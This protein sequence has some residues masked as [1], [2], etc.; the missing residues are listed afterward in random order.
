MVW[1]ALQ[2]YANQY[3]SEWYQPFGW[4]L[5]LP[6]PAIFEMIVLHL[7]G[8]K[9]LKTF[10][11]SSNNSAM[12]SCISTMVYLTI[13]LCIAVRHMCVGFTSTLW[14]IAWGLK[15]A[16]VY[17]VFCTIV[18]TAKEYHRTR[19]CF[20]NFDDSLKNSVNLVFSVVRGLLRKIISRVLKRAVILS[21]P[22]VM[23][24]LSTTF[25]EQNAQVVANS[26]S[27]TVGLLNFYEG[28]LNEAE[29]MEDKSFSHCFFATSIMKACFTVVALKNGNWMLLA[30]SNLSLLCSLVV[31]KYCIPAGQLTL[32]SQAFRLMIHSNKLLTYRVA[33]TVLSLHCALSI[34]GFILISFCGVF[35]CVGAVPL[36]WLGKNVRNIISTAG[37]KLRLLRPKSLV[38]WILG[39]SGST[40]STIAE[41][42]V[43]NSPILG[44]IDT[45]EK[46]KQDPTRPKQR[47]GESKVD[48]FKRMK[49]Y[50]ESRPLN[51]PKGLPLTSSMLN[52][53][54][55]EGD[56]VPSLRCSS[57]GSA[58][59]C[60][61]CTVERSGACGGLTCDEGHFTC[62]KC[63]E[64]WAVEQNPSD[65][66]DFDR[67]AHS[68]R[69]DG[70]LYCPGHSRGHCQAKGFTYSEL[71][72]HLSGE[73]LHRC[74][75]IEC[76]TKTK[77]EID[78]VH[79][80][81][82]KLLLE[83]DKQKEDAEHEILIDQL[84]RLHPNARMCGQCSFGPIDHGWC[85][86]LRA[87]H[88]QKIGHAKIN[89]SC[90]KCGWF[91]ENIEQWPK[92]DGR[93]WLN[94]KPTVLKDN[95]YISACTISVARL[96]FD[97]QEMVDNRTLTVEQARE[98]MG[99]V[100]PRAPLTL[101]PGRDLD[102]FHGDCLKL[103]SIPA[104]Y[105]TFLNVQALMAGLLPATVWAFCLCAYPIHGFIAILAP[106]WKHILFVALL[107]GGTCALCE[108][109]RLSFLNR[110]QTPFPSDR[111]SLSVCKYE[112]YDPLKRSLA[113]LANYLFPERDHKD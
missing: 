2:G 1:G 51:G 13:Y 19:L 30:M 95:E 88:G 71:A 69:M 40:A 113:R 5:A 73:S 12:V 18:A 34:F 28:L 62:N 98:M 85:T 68:N 80:L 97:L 70:K 14:V 11:G 17:P 86:N 103:M 112:S 105:Y 44:E 21:H 77:R 49:L 102:E 35:L 42:N 27:F 110:S 58:E 60:I 32:P 56:M 96:T 72:S 54:I 31:G 108:L 9:S 7:A 90:P 78:K 50:N 107:A 46:L 36:L 4:G 37:E 48:F 10:L 38:Q 53:T 76:K 61:V 25:Q 100:P 99:N 39:K 104:V 3:F 106:A 55:P 29:T 33:L 83:K 82:Y 74:I 84:L 109:K 22:V 81:Y 101:L 45:L 65:S 75:E 43:P 23:R 64:G 93:L 16:S 91:R 66:P 52:A 57:S 47:K 111:R 15:G 92:W 24:A 20:Y 67:M 79:A 26:F 6:I 41:E 63:I 89:N 94:R 59:A 8:E 87:H